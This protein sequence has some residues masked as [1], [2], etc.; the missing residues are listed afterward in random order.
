MKKILL[1]DTALATTNIG[2]EIIFQSVK[3]GLNPIIENASIYRMGTHV[4]NY[5][6][7]QMFL[8]KYIY[9][10]KKIK[11]INEEADFKFICGTNML[12]D[13]LFRPR[14]QFMLNPTNKS[15]YFDS[16]LVGVGRVA[17]YSE[18]KNS[19]TKRLYLSILSTKYKHSVRDEA[20][21]HILE[22]IGIN[23]INTGCPTLWNFTS[24]K[25]NQIPSYKAENVIFSVSGYESQRDPIN[26]KCMLECLKQNYKKMY[27]WIQ[28]AVDEEYLLNLINVKD[29]NIKFVYSLEMFN[30]IADFGN[31]D[32]IGTRLHGGIYAMQH[33]VRSLIIA[34][35][36]RAVGFH[37]SN[38]IPILKRENMA[39]LDSV[40]N[41]VLVT[42]I[43]LNR[44]A[45]DEFLIQF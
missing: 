19:F 30:K 7:F 35:D 40:I 10:D 1:F 3:E 11:L 43:K 25:C 29:Y 21:K 27:A 8:H 31:V 24:E 37:E 2:D 9:S 14:A 34:I 26:D 12:V 38:N 28:T 20:T 33:N 36:E 13:N 42:E 32:Y 16:V 15:L 41:D 45:I 39:S 18:F 6:P 22:D 23:C 5:S 44:D 4:E 17:D